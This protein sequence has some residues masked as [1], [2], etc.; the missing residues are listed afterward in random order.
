ML[1]LNDHLYTKL[2]CLFLSS[3]FLVSH[4]RLRTPGHFY[5]LSS[6]ELCLTTI[7]RSFTRGGVYPYLLLPDTNFIYHIIQPCDSVGLRP[8]LPSPP[9]QTQN[10]VL[11][12][13][14]HALTP[15]PCHFPV[16]MKC[17]EPLHVISCHMYNECYM[18]NT[19]NTTYWVSWTITSPAYDFHTSFYS[20]QY[21]MHTYI[22]INIQHV[23]LCSRNDTHTIKPCNIR[24]HI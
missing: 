4:R 14:N 20:C 11:I 7:D 6:L 2:M 13:F 9:N 1:H 21:I 5:G 16:H 22:N 15:I 12:L 23:I 17:N 19:I 8:T 18:D 24:F 3:E 10:T